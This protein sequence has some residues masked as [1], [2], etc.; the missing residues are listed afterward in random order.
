MPEL[1]DRYRAASAH[2]APRA[3]HAAAAASFA[4][5]FDL[6][7]RAHGVALYC[8]PDGIAGRLDGPGWTVW[9]AVELLPD[10]IRITDAAS[11]HPLAPLPPTPPDIS[12]GY[13]KLTQDPARS[14]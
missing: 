8:A 9:R 12:L 10:R 11:P 4:G 14:V 7:Q 13:G 5:P 3:L 6:V 2:A 1:R